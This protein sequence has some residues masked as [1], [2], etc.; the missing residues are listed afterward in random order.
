MKD[1]SN[2]YK[3]SSIIPLVDDIYDMITWGD[4]ARCYF[5]DRSVS[6]F[7]NKMRG[8]DGNGGAGAFTDEER[9]QLSEG[10]IQL[11]QRIRSAADRIVNSKT[12]E[13]ESR[14]PL[15]DS[16]CDDL[17]AAGSGG[18]AEVPSRDG[19]GSATV[20]HALGRG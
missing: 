14:K 13:R 5:P 6:W 3:N 15:R 8:V 12:I 9:R 2:R 10:L 11:S 4:F 20:R 17:R 16:G 7:Y 19:A 18:Q 1:I